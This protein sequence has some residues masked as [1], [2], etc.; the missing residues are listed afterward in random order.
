MKRKLIF[1]K[2]IDQ[3]LDTSDDLHEIVDGHCVAKAAQ[4]LGSLGGKA[5]VKKYGKKHFSEAGKKGM[6]KRWGKKA[7]AL[8]RVR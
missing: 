7:E 3:I 4:Q 1:Q 2:E 8:E 5:T 6:A